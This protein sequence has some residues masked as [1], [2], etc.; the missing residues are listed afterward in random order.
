MIELYAAPTSNG[1]RARI[2]LEECGLDY[3][4]HMVNLLAGEHKR[5]PYLSINPM[6]LIPTLVD[7]EGP[8]GNPITLAQSL[9]ILTYLAGK[10]GM[11]MPEN[12]MQDMIF[13][14]DIMSIGTD[15]G[16]M[17]M[18]VLTI[19]REKE[20]HVPTMDMFGKRFND[21]LKVWDGMMAERRYCTGDEIT[22]ADFAMY[23]LLLRC[24]NVVPKY[25]E[26]C[27]NIDRWYEE[28][29]RRPAVQRA[30]DFGS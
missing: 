12:R 29:D 19:G 11:F 5:E 3:T 9:T 1:I 15:L 8:D 7:S 25:G 14:Q 20:P 28:I 17:L 18:S 22:I 26:G 2:M 24:R 16:G 30:I 6:G 23:P 4:L 21:L 27:P 10:S 13:W